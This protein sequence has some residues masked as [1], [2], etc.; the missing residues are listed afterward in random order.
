[1]K[2]I[3][4]FTLPEE[5]EEFELASKAVNLLIALNEF[6]YYL[7]NLIKHGH[8]FT[9]IEQALDSVHRQFWSLIEQNSLS[10]VV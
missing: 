7:R 2:G 1:M 5:S 10:D 6:D 8:N 4:E 9:G 3:L